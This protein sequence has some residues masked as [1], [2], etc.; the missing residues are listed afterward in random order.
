MLNQIKLNI[1]RHI[2]L[3][4]YLCLYK[5]AYL[6]ASDFLWEKAKTY[7][8]EFSI[9]VRGRRLCENTSKTVSSANKWKEWKVMQPKKR[10]ITK[11]NVSVPVLFL[12]FK[13]YL[14][15]TLIYSV[16]SYIKITFTRFRIGR[17]NNFRFLR[18]YRI[19]SKMA[20]ITITAKTLVQK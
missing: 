18:S 5:K 11:K 19:K 7:T 14:Y 3:S 16:L 15:K 2:C 1:G 9:I 12:Y 17:D 4:V 20:V 10:E 13:S 8:L 6:C